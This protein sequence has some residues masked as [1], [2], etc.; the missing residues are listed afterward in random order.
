MAI[1]I[2]IRTFKLIILQMMAPIP[3][4]TYIDPK[5]SKD[6]AFSSWLKTFVSTYIDIFIKLATVYLLLLLVSKVFAE[7]EIV[8]LKILPKALCQKILLWFSW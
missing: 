3:V 2:A 6:G 7:M 1:E 4:M 5:S 8:Y